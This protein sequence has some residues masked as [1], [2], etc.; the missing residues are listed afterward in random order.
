MDVVNINYFVLFIV[1]KQT[2]ILS[3]LSSYNL[4]VSTSFRPIQISIRTVNSLIVLLV[5][6]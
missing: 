6:V 5:I 4:N 1:I 2:K 3:D